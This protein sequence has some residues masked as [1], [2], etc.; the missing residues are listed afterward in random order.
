MACQISHGGSFEKWH[1]S[2]NVYLQE[3]IPENGKKER[4]EKLRITNYE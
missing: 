3:K 1:S 2:R 4:K